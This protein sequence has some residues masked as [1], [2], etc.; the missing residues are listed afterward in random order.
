SGSL[1]A[2]G[3]LGTTDV[4]FRSTDDGSSFSQLPDVPFTFKGLSSRGAKLYGV[5]ENM[6]DPYAIY[7]STDEG[8]SWQPLMAFGTND[9]QPTPTP[10]I[11]AIVSCLKAYCQTDCENR[12][13]MQLFSLD[14]SDEVCSAAVMPAPVDAGQ[15]GTPQDAGRPPNNDG[16]SHKDASTGTSKDASTGAPPPSSDG[17]KCALP[18][19]AI[20][21]WSWL[22]LLAA[23]LVLARRRRRR[24][25]GA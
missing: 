11:Q 16:G 19:Q 22:A 23:G 8:M 13:G 3:V 1:I 21:S 9:M 4:A 14:N 5:A 17:C 15:G 12:A 2:G 10:V 25:S 20:W 6:S 7:T 18:G 24:S